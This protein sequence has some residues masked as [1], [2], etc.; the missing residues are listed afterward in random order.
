[1]IL[2]FFQTKLA[3]GDSVNDKNNHPPDDSSLI[4][5]SAIAI[6]SVPADFPNP[7]STGLIQNVP[8]I[9]CSVV[10]ACQNG[11]TCL[12]TDDEKGY[13][14]S[15]ASGFAGPHCQSDQRPCRDDT[16][17]NAGNHILYL[18]L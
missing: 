10:Q 11:G 5:N 14:C 17:W 16:C 15:C 13:N 6:F 12:D 9:L 4:S 8:R 2:F 18:G 7:T 1:M 3:T